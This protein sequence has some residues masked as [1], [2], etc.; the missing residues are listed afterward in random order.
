MSKVDIFY[1]SGTGNSLLVKRELQKY[2]P[3]ANYIP[4]VSQ[5]G[6]EKFENNRKRRFYFPS[7]LCHSSF[8]CKAFC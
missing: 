1:F 3:A 5:L 4:I 2:I 8:T 7:L 6:K